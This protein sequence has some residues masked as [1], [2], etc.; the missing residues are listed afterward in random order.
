MLQL[1][2][3]KQ[4]RLTFDTVCRFQSGPLHVFFKKETDVMFYNFVFQKQL[5]CQKSLNVAS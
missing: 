2:I 3:W 4:L 1:K 5:T